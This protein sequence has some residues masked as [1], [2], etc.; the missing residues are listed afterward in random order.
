MDKQ[1]FKPNSPD[2][3]YQ[4]IEGEYILLNRDN[5]NYFSLDNLGVFAWD[6]VINS[7]P[8]KVFKEAVASLSEGVSEEIIRSAINIFKE[9]QKEGL[10]VSTDKGSND[11]KDFLN[12]IK[13]KTENGEIEI[14]PVKLHSYKN[15]QEKYAHPCGIKEI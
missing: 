10:A 8:V 7:I 1:I 15:I 14:K 13:E 12:R 11:Y 5:G 9:F 2:V 4:L 3:I 6:C